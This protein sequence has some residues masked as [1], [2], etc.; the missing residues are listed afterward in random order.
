MIGK[1]SKKCVR[2]CSAGQIDFQQ[3]LLQLS[4]HH[5]D[6]LVTRQSDRVLTGWLSKTDRH[7]AKR[8]S[9]SV[10]QMSLLQV[11]TH[12]FFRWGMGG[13][14]NIRAMIMCNLLSLL[15]YVPSVFESHSEILTP[16]LVIHPSI[17]SDDG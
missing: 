17:A 15:Q 11:K 7:S 2:D 8:H 9:S 13:A 12:A 4:G 3:A 10:F 1:C 6:R 16:V 14:I 5:M